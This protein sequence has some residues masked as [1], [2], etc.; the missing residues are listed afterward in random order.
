MRIDTLEAIVR[1]AVSAA[2][3]MVEFAFQGGEP[4]LAGLEFYE[5]FIELLKKYNKNGTPVFHK[6]QTNGLMID[7]KW[8]DFFHVNEFLVGLSIDGTGDMH[9][10]N[11]QDTDGKGTYRRCLNTL[12]LLRKS[13]VE[14]NALCVVTDQIASKAQSV[15][16]NLKKEGFSYMQFIPCLDPLDAKGENAGILLKPE[17]YARF[18]K[19][20]F[21]MW[22][23]DWEKGDYISIRSFDDYVHILAG[24]PPS[25]C[26]TSGV[27]GRY[28]TI[29]SDGGVYPCDFYTIDRW[30]L[31]NIN[32]ISL[33]ALFHNQKTTDFI[34]EGRTTPAKCKSCKHSIL[35][36]GGC[37]RN[38]AGAEGLN[39]Y[40]SAFVEFFDYSA[41]RLMRIASLE[42]ILAAN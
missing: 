29:E 10:R 18:L 37:K 16:E 14:V 13:G 22:Y 34:E 27:C 20:M 19:T 15:Y 12:K 17:K 35:C 4:T 11:R 36:R 5:S 23:L 2:Y 3:D 26:A 9:D 28:L 21:D 33:D 31:G 32:D 40:C 25:S 8:A 1:Q 24:H 38:R 30:C 42:R 39:T 41:E 7:E 6:I